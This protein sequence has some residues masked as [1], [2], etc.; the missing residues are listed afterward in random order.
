MTL[1]TIR[2]TIKLRRLVVAFA[3][4]LVAFTAICVAVYYVDRNSITS[5][6]R[7]MREEAQT[8]VYRTGEALQALIRSN[9]IALTRVE[10]AIFREPSISQKELGALVADIYAQDNQLAEISAIPIGGAPYTVVKDGGSPSPDP[11]NEDFSFSPPVIHSMAFDH[12]AKISTIKKIGSGKYGIYVHFPVYVRKDGVDMLWGHIKGIIDPEKVFQKAGLLDHGHGLTFAIYPISNSVRLNDFEPFFPAQTVSKVFTTDPVTQHITAVS[13]EWEI[14]AIPKQGWV[15][16][17]SQ[18]L[19][20]RLIYAAL[21]LAVLYPLLKSGW[22]QLAHLRNLAELKRQK[23]EIDLANQRLD[24]ALESSGAGLWNSENGA[25]RTFWDARMFE[26]HGLPANDGFLST[27]DWLETIHPDDREHSYAIL[28]D[29]LVNDTPFTNHARIIHPDGSVR[30]VRYIGRV[31]AG[32]HDRKTFTGIAYDVTEDVQK[33]K[34][35]EQAKEEAERK[36]SELEV[37]QERIQHHA[38]HDS[39]TGLANRRLLDET[40]ESLESRKRQSNDLVTILHIDLDRFKQINDTLGH[41][42]GDA[43]LV[44]AAKVLRNNVRQKDVVARIGGDEFVVLIRGKET[45]DDVSHL[46]RRI[47]EE[48]RAPVRFEGHECRF[49]VSVGIAMERHTDCDLRRLL[50]NADIALYRAKAHGRNRFEFFTDELET[51]IRHTKQLA[52]EILTGIERGEFVAWYQPQFDAKTYEISG[53]EAL[54]R[55]NHPERGLLAPDAFLKTAEDINALVSLDRLVL[56][57]VLNDRLKWIANGLMLPKVSVNVSARRLRDDMMV[58]TMRDLSIEPG[59]IAFE[60]VESIFLD[61]ADEEITRNIAVLKELGVDIEID[62]FGT[63]HTSIVSLLKLE[64]SRLK[65]DRQLVAPMLTSARERSLVRSILEIGASLDIETVAEGVETLKHAEALRKLGCTSL[66]GYAFA[67][68]M[69]ADELLD[70]A[71]K[72]LWKQP[73]Q[74]VK[75]ANM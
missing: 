2:L 62:D 20:P 59:Q 45:R 53:A 66:Q 4:P 24:M 29:A 55:W 26:L 22:L 33:T 28:L 61:D 73:E 39:L 57:Q 11:T 23:N 5:E 15:I 52:D 21:S 74:V 44:H 35:L 68:A 7:D 38:T 67:R 13:A 30:Y 19:L 34:A 18:Q 64:P 6:I 50:V 65:V 71:Q 17:F 72:K 54:V 27:D 75:A 36:N 56:E 43:M 14:G 31:R 12:N 16:P 58:N 60:L 1:R 40:L 8:E 42:A 46:A 48:M 63:G 3:V 25:R 10:R 47:V 32:T 37:V 9:V 41:A 70:F 69:P 51:E 49:G